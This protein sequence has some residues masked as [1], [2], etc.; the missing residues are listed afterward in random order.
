[1][2]RSVFKEAGKRLSVSVAIRVRSASSMAARPN[3]IG[4]EETLQSRASFES[5][6][7]LVS[8]RAC[9]F[10]FPALSLSLSLSL[11]LGQG[12]TNASSAEDTLTHRLPRAH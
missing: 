10:G 6:V 5:V 3:A 7:L 9:S 12:D 8:G 4:K 1:M 11:S 2:I